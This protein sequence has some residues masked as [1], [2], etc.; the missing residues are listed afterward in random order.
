M[1]SNRF[2]ED[3]YQDDIKA[4]EVDMSKREKKGDIL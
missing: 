2:D 4:H 1:I 3:N